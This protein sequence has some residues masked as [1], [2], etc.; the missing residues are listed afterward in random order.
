M[1]SFLN[2]GTFLQIKLSADGTIFNLKDSGTGAAT[3]SPTVL[4]KLL[5]L[6][7]LLLLPQLQL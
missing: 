5:L 4:L 2:L 3:A 6:I 7:L 1:N